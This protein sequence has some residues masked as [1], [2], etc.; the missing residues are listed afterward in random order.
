MKKHHQ[1][2]VEDTLNNFLSKPVRVI[3]VVLVLLLVLFPLY[4][5]ASN[6]VKTE[7]EYLRNPP[8][9]V[10]STLTLD[11]YTSVFAKADAGRGLY[12]TVFVSVFTT[13]CC[14]FFGSMAGYSIAKGRLHKKVRSGISLWFMIQKMYPAVCVAIPIY[15][16]MRNVGLIDTLPGLVIV[17]TSFNLPLTIWLMVGF[18]QDLP[19]EIEQSGMIDGCNMYQRFFLLA[20][21][22]TKPGIIAAAILAFNA[23]WNE[24]LFSCI[25]SIN[26]SKT[27]SVVI[28]G[29]ITD[30]GLEWGPMAALSMILIVPVVLLVWAVQKD[31]ISGLAMGSVKE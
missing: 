11:N 14:V 23:A 13:V 15:L 5:L 12:N 2:S 8:V 24:F 20:L 7:S 18:F 3:S 22:I 31:F 28:S 10:P 27:L 29:F 26:K 4:W 6:A 1:F 30:K 21:P 25:L 9:L 16:V 17:N 19:E